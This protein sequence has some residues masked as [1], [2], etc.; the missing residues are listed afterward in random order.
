MAT[1]IWGDFSN[2]H[3][4]VKIETNTS[5]GLIFCKNE[6]WILLAAACE[7]KEKNFEH[8]EYYF[9]AGDVYRVDKK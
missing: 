2:F 7:P 8:I 3:K 1:Y 6:F 5:F 4:I 9:G